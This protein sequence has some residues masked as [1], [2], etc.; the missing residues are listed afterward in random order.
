MW[1]SAKKMDAA[2]LISQITE[3]KLGQVTPVFLKNPIPHC[4]VSTL[5]IMPVLCM[6]VHFLHYFL[7]AVS[8]SLLYSDRSL[9]IVCKDKK[10]F[11]TWTTALKV[12]AQ[13]LIHI[14]K[15]LT[16]IL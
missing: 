16:Y 12:M 5:H 2:V 13:S 11:D 10:E 7:K 15:E 4:E 8:F 3:I 9:D 6:Y 14:D 1:E